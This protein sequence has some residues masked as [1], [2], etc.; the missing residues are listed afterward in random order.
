MTE[1]N[2]NDLFY[3]CSLT[4]IGKL[5]TVL[6]AQCCEDGK[7]AEELERI[8]KSYFRTGLYYQNSDYLNWSYKEGYLLA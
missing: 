1:K 3:V 5:Y 2:R 8:F 7:E 6:I 4:D